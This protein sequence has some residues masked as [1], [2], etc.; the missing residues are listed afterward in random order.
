M[1]PG[2]LY[3]YESHF[4]RIPQLSSPSCS[5]HAAPDIALAFGYSKAM[6]VKPAP[7]PKP[8]AG[9]ADGAVQILSSC[10]ATRAWWIF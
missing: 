2:V 5:G 7:P 9:P 6:P 1:Y 8:Q 4:F 3:R 10:S